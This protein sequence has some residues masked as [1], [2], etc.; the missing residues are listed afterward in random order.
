MLLALLYE[1]KK[2]PPLS[3]TKRGQE[4][5]T[6]RHGTYHPARGGGAR[7]CPRISVFVGGNAVI[8][9]LAGNL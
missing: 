1:E 8:F 4:L 6:L 7:A 3:T 9:L 5:I 2:N